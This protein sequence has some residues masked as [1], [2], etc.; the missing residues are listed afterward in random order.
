MTIGSKE[1]SVLIVDD[2]SMMRRLMASIIERAPGLRV[3]GSAA[4]AEEG[5][6][7]FVSGKP[8]AVLL[9]MELPGRSGFALLERIM[10]QSPC[11]VVMVSARGASVAD[12]AIKA[13]ELGAIDFVDKPNAG[14]QTLESFS[15]A[16]LRLLSPPGR[17]E[18]P[19]P[20]VM[21]PHRLE[22]S[23]HRPTIGAPAI[24]AIGASTGGVPALAV[25]AKGLRGFRTPVVITQH[26]PPGYTARL[27]IGLAEA[28]GL[29]AREA[30]H[31]DRP[32]PGL[33]LIAPGGAHLSVVRDGLG[34]K[35]VVEAGPLVSGHMPSVDVL[36]DSV[37]AQFGPG[38]I[39]VLLTGMG[40]DGA[41]GL[42]ALRKAGARTICQDEATSVVYGM[43]RA[44]VELGAAEAV[45]PLGEIARRLCD[46]SGRE[47]A[48][49][50]QRA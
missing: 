20:P 33:I 34:A 32:Q 6:E 44:A 12:A 38:A 7:L 19:R 42:L 39:G 11:P 45:L 43:P 3:A 28:S 17:S 2:S 50:L 46:L 22:P 15:A 8:D 49:I 5:W 47:T 9:D 37:A 23:P 14:S 36:F 21:L 16:V 30:R 18:P 4:S 10:R 40:R 48:R 31:G 41:N 27:A 13:L 25:L 24:V 29:A 26:M 35:C 1:R